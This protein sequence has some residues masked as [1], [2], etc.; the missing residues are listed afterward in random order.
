MR[1][2]VVDGFHGRTEGP[3]RLSHSCRP[4]YAK[5]LASFRGADDLVFVPVNDIAALERTFADA[6]G[7]G[8]FIEAVFVEPVMGEGVPG[9]AMTRGSTTRFA[10]PPPRQARCSSLTRSRPR[11]APRVASRLWTT[12]ASSHVRRRTSRRPRRRSTRVSFRCRSLR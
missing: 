5:H 11:C 12:R 7:E 10:R 2:A 8:A 4:A 6:A 3:A 1:V 9:L